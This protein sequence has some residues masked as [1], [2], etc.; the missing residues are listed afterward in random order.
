MQYIKTYSGKLEA[1]GPVIND[2]PASGSS[3]SCAFYDYLRLD[4]NGQEIFL[5]RVMIPAYLDSL[6]KLGSVMTLGVVAVPVPTTFFGSKPVH[7]VYAL[8][9]GGKAR[10]G[11]D[12]AV[13]LHRSIKHRAFTLFWYGLILLPAW[14][15]GVLFWI[16]AIRLI[17]FR[18]PLNDM[19]KY[20][21]S[22]YT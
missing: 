22:V 10:M 21:V 3:E 4:G 12:Q 11:I 19:R 5:E 14:G 6:A 17:T 2:G 20:Q 1:T 13:R 8:E 7:L 9:T 15:F 18:L 16:R